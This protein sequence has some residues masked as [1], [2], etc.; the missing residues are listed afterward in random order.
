MPDPLAC[1][2]AVVNVNLAAEEAD[3]RAEHDARRAAAEARR[4]A[5]FSVDPEPSDAGREEHQDERHNERGEPP[6]FPAPAPPVHPH[7]RPDATLP[8]SSH[9]T[10]S[11]CSFLDQIR[12]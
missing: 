1:E 4:D 7:A 9:D 8:A 10:P 12:H 5:F 3:E 2:Q 6:A 11:A